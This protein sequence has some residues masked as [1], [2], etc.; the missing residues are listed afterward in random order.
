MFIQFFN[1]NNVIL[2]FSELNNM[3]DL[4]SL[5]NILCSVSLLG[6]SFLGFVH[7]SGRLVDNVVRGV[8]FG[9]GV[10]Q[11]KWL[12]DKIIDAV[13][14]GKPESTGASLPKGP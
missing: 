10:S 14:G 11:G 7:F 8:G 1:F 13:T 5:F 2:F 3:V 12:G 4:F 6:I 9:L